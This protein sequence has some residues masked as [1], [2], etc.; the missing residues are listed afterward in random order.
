MD[1]VLWFA[2]PARRTLRL[3]GVCSRG[4]DWAIRAAVL[5]GRRGCDSLVSGPPSPV[6]IPLF[7]DDVQGCRDLSMSSVL[8]CTHE[9]RAQC[10]QSRRGSISVVQYG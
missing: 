7:G 3:G 1:D 4:A 9:Q 10:S 5:Q 2:G 8:S 6:Y